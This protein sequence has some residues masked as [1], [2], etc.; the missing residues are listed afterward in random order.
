MRLDDRPLRVLRR[1][2]AA[3]EHDLDLR[4]PHPR[5]GLDARC[6]SSRSRSRTGSPTAQAAVD[7]GLSPDDFG[8][9]LSFFFNAHNHFFQE[10]A[11]FRAARRL[12]ARDHARALRRDE[13]EGAGAALP[14]ADRR[15]DA[16]RAAAGEQHRARRDPGAR[17]RSAAA[18]SRSTRTAFDEALALPTERA[19]TIA[20]RTQQILAARGGHDGHRRSARRLVLHR[21]A[22]RRARGARAGADRARRRARR[23]GR[24]DRAGLRPGAR[25]RPSAFRYQSDVESGER[26]VVGVNAFTEDE[27]RAESSSCT[28]TRRSS[29]ASASARRACAPSVTA[30]AAARALAEVRRTAEHRREP[31]ARHARGASRALHRRRDLWR[32]PRALGYI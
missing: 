13:P 5:G 18:R 9:R 1:A 6:R 3:L 4:V 16:D 22:H 15:L 23:R 10:V 11:K 30:D 2:A 24:G 21:G 26:V 19:A 28:S 12:W 25:S 32:P 29:A 31:P 27:A 17:R 20:L 7:A 14:R 8:E